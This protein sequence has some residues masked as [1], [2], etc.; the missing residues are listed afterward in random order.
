MTSD[1]SVRMSSR[2]SRFLITRPLKTL[3]ALI[4]MLGVAIA[5]YTL[6]RQGNAH[7]IEGYKKRNLELQA[8]NQKLHE[9]DAKQAAYINDLQSELK[10]VKG[11]L[12]AIVHPESTFEIIPNESK[13]VAGGNLTVGLVGS[14]SNDSININVNGKQQ[15]AAAGDVIKVAIGSSTNCRVKV[16]SFEMFRAV[17]TAICAEVKP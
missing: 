12:D 11:Q 4:V 5:I 8:N 1:R 15:S 7:E 6:G 2:V 10:S 9:D 13:V 17:V 3:S 16:E 14:P